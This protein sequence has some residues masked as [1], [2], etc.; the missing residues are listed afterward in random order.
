MLA[1]GRGTHPRQAPNVHGF[2][3]YSSWHM[4]GVTHVT[5]G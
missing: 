1:E 5:S 4:R 2:A 3:R